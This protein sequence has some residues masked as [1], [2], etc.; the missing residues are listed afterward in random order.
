LLESFG[1]PAW[2]S[3]AHRAKDTFTVAAQLGIHTQ[4]PINFNFF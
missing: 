1:Y 2:Y 3:L 4:F